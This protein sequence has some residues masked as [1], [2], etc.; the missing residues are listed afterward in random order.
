MMYSPPSLADVAHC[1]LQHLRAG[2]LEQPG[3]ELEAPD[4]V[5][6]AAHGKVQPLHVDVH[7]VEGQEAV[8]IS[9]DVQ[10]T[11]RAPPPE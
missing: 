6:H 9:A 3:V 2:A 8:R 7:A 11:G 5:L 4:R 1:V 10:L